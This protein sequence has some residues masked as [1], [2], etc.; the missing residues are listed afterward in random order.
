MKKKFSTKWKASRQPRKKR[1]FIANAPLHLKRKMLGANLSKELRGKYGRSTEIR[2]GDSVVVMRG[3][4]KKKTGKIADIKMKKMKVSIEGIQSNKKDGSKIPVWFHPSKLKIVALSLEDRKR[5]KDRSGGEVSG[6]EK[7]AMGKNEKEK[8]SE[9][10]K[11]K[12]KQEKKNVSKKTS[13]A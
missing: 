7:K 13:N 6:K 1:K 10:K 8:E 2:K 12:T 3:K 4:F 9:I 5:F 11:E